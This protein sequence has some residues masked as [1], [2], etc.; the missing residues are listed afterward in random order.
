MARKSAVAIAVALVVGGGVVVG[1]ARAVTDD[2]LRKPIVG[3]PMNPGVPDLTNTDGSVLFTT[4][5]DEV[6]YPPDFCAGA[7]ITIQKTDGSLRRTAVFNDHG[8]IGHPPAVWAFA[9]GTIPLANGAGNWVATAIS[10]NGASLAIS[11]PFTVRRGSVVGID[12]PVPAPGYAT[13]TGIARAYNGS[14]TLAATPRRGVGL[15][16]QAYPAGG[17]RLLGTAYADAAGRYRFRLA[18]SAPVTFWVKTYDNATYGAARSSNVTARV[19]A[20]LSPLSASSRAYI[21]RWWGVS[22]TALPATNK[23]NTTLFR[24]D[25]TQWVSTN[26][27][28]PPGANGAFSR[29]WK[30]TT[31]GSYRMRVELSG[32]G[33]DNTPL[34]REIGVTVTAR[35]TYLTG[36]ADAT[37]ATVIRPGTKMSTF[38]H[39]TAM[40]TTGATGAFAGQQV[41]IQT[42]P[43]GQTTVPYTTVA[44]ATT[45]ST[46]YYYANWTARSDVDVRAAFVSPYQSVGSVF[47][48]IRAIDVH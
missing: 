1:P 37:N 42:R 38:G 14:G 13:I 41:V 15:Y 16:V 12:Q 8:G 17:E 11:V 47:H 36:T 34:S 30:P 23:M 26:S 48:Y 27:Y 40:Y 44:T 35:P 19:L 25:G 32:Q 10:H 22:G 7:T 6:G 5:F 29:W 46:G 2:C 39:L 3:T 20:S 43:R 45:T 31:A 18:I 33:P 28:G 4:V 21:G 9:T 24:W